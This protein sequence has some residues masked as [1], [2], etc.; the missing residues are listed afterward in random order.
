[1]RDFRSETDKV[2]DLPQVMQYIIGDVLDIGC[3][4]HKITPN[5][6]GVDGRLLPGVDVV[7]EHEDIWEKVRAFRKD[8]NFISVFDTI[9]SSHFLEHL[10]DQYGAIKVWEMMLKRGGHL[11]LYLPHGDNYD[12]KENP[13]HMVDIKYDPFMFWIK[14]AFCGEGKDFKGNNL[15][16]VFELIDSG[17]DLRPNCY[18]FFVIL[19]KL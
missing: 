12:N 1:M 15:P 14:R 5:A 6:T 2:I 17:M 10:P 16:K 18:S 11:I 13:E 19:R 4:V 9:Y 7:C 3:G 8:N